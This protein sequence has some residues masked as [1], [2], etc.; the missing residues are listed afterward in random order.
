MGDH[1]WNLI[2]YAF[3]GIQYYWYL[4][5]YRY[6]KLSPSKLFHVYGTKSSTHVTIEIDEKDDDYNR[7]QMRPKSYIIWIQEIKL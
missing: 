1:S 6:F 4:N 3:S 7:H 2:G 5:G